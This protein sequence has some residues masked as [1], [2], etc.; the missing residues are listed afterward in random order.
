VYSQTQTKQNGIQD[1]HYIYRHME[2]YWTQYARTFTGT[3]NSNEHSMHTHLQ[4]HGTLLNTVCM[5]IYRHMEQYWTQ[6]AHKLTATRNS[7]VNSIVTK[8]FDYTV[9]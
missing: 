8:H 1:V 2:Q 4:A 6:Y 9:H 3:W 5:H 7:T